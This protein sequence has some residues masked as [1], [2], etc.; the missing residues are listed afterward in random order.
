VNVTLTDLLGRRIVS[1]DGRVLGRLHDVQIDSTPARNHPQDHAVVGALLYG[2]RGLLARLGWKPP[3]LQ[4]SLRWEHV[5][6]VRRD[7]ALVT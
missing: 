6:E 4:T 2:R 5:K 7:G 3:A 1:A